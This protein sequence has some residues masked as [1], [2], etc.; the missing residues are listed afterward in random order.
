MFELSQN[1]DFKT[2]TTKVISAFSD[3]SSESN[4]II[5]IYSF[6]AIDQWI[7]SILCTIPR[8]KII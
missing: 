6:E 2:N 5:E 3:I 7:E 4:S 8:R 1:P